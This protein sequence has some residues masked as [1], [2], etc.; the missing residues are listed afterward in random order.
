MFQPSYYR[1]KPKKEIASLPRS[2]I[3]SEAELAI[4]AEFPSRNARNVTSPYISEER[5]MS[6]TPTASAS[7]L[8]SWPMTASLVATLE[9]PS[10][11][12]SS[13][14]PTSGLISIGMS[15]VSSAT[16]IFAL[17]QNPLVNEPK[18]GSVPSPFRNADGVMFLW[19]TWVHC[20]LAPLWVLY[21]DIFSSSSTALLK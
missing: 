20:H 2:L 1:R 17:E 14:A 9:D 8:S 21:I 16:V 7:E 10:I 4:I 3:P 13:A 19:T 15:S 5:S 11:T 18:D 6:Q 12:N